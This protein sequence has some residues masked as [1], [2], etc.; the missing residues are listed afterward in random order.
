MIVSIITGFYIII[1]WNENNLELTKVENIGKSVEQD[2]LTEKMSM[3]LHKIKTDLPLLSVGIIESAFKIS[4]VLFMFMW[5]PLLEKAAGAKV[6]PGSIFVCFMLAR[7]IGSELYDGIK[8]HLK[9]NTYILSIFVTI[10]GTIS[11]YVEYQFFYFHL[12]FCMLI[13]FDGLSGIIFPLMSSLKSQ[14]IPEELRTTIMTFFRIPINICCIL[15]LYLSSWVSTLSIC[16]MCTGIMAVSAIVNV[17]LFYYHN[18]PDAEK[19]VVQ[20]TGQIIRKNSK[21]NLNELRENNKLLNNNT[22]DSMN[23]DEDTK[24]A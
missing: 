22:D 16:L 23:D 8:K 11:F 3:A 12:V 19:R 5:T 9:T 6:H 1:T 13:Y 17:M 4:L 7:L 15:A 21:L 24:K 20:T 18:P 2:S 14:M 10:T